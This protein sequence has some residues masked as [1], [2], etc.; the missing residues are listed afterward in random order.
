MPGNLM[1]ELQFGLKKTYGVMMNQKTFQFFITFVLVIGIFL[2]SIPVG[3][4]VAGRDAGTG[5]V[6]FFLAVLSGMILFYTADLLQK[7][8]PL[9]NGQ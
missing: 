3:E 1:K 9:S 5:Q 4:F 8:Y 6:V 2:I 7:R